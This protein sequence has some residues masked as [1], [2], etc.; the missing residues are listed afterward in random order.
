MLKLE[1]QF[2]SSCDDCDQFEP[3][4]HTKKYADGKHDTT[5]YCEKRKLCEHI[6]KHLVAHNKWRNPVQ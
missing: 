3:E 4:V 2:A 5:I 6:A 1:K